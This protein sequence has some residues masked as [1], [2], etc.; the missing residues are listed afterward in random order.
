M[1]CLI[2]CHTQTAAVVVAHIKFH[3][4]SSTYVQVVPVSQKYNFILFFGGGFH[5]LDLN[6]KK[7]DSG[8]P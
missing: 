5:L 2:F 8:Y 7:K 4:M 3:I 6:D 1:L